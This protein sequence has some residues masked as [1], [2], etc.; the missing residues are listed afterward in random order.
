MDAQQNVFNVGDDL[1]KVLAVVAISHAGDIVTK[2]LSISC[3]ATSRTFWLP[4]LTGP[5]LGLN[6]H[7][8]FEMD[9]SLSR[10]E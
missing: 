6:G 8:R 3:D 5:Q 1:A 7:N 10:N 2:K 9:T 4:L